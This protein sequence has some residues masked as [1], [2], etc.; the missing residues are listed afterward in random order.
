MGS[1]MGSSSTQISYTL[2]LGNWILSIPWSYG[3]KMQ[4]EPIFFT[5]FCHDSLHWMCC[6]TLKNP[7]KI[8]QLTIYTHFSSDYEYYTNQKKSALRH[9]FHHYILVIYNINNIVVFFGYT[10]PN[11]GFTVMT[12]LSGFFFFNLS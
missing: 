1:L 2:S 3:F 7:S 11:F 4:V 6:K 12:L 10:Y 9:H 5:N 8:V